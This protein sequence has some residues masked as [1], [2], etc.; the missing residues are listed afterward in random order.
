MK[1]IKLLALFI[2]IFLSLLSFGDEIKE[3][4]YYVGDKIVLK[5]SG[6]ISSEDIK[7]HMKEFK[8]YSLD[9]EKDSSYIVTFS[10]YE[11][12]EKEIILGDKRLKLLISSSLTEEDREPFK[13]LSDLNNMYVEKDYPYLAIISGMS[14]I[15]TI[16]LAIALYII[17]RLKNPY[18]IFK[19]GISKVNENNWTEKI[20]LELRKYIDSVYKTN[21]LGGDYKLVSLLTH[22][23]IDFIQKMD[24]LKFDPNTVSSDEKY[25]EYK[26]KAVEI[27]EKLRKEKNSV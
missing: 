26:K 27:V 5:I 12:G 22:N 16:L 13:E 25:L 10:S 21:F 20:S 18:I 4:K 7:E 23:D 6:D 14:G 3:N 24:Y 1:K 15:F 9:K 8:I 2:F 11:V 19:K 17:N